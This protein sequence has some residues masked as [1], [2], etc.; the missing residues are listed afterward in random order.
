MSSDDIVQ[1]QEQEQEQAQVRAIKVQEQELCPLHLG[2]GLPQGGVEAGQLPHRY[3]SITVTVEQGPGCPHLGKER[4]FPLRMTRKDDPSAFVFC[5]Q[6][7]K[8]C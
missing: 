7:M 5:A 2:E 3:T 8:S 6:L 1:E 4:V